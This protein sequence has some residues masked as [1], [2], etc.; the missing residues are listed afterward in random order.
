MRHRLEPSANEL[1]KSMQA[2]KY[3][4]R[5]HVG[6]NDERE[7]EDEA[8]YDNDRNHQISQNSFEE[9]SILILPFDISWLVRWPDTFKR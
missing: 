1:T 9:A 8:G 5:E 6:S 3:V 4:V 2:K 7:G